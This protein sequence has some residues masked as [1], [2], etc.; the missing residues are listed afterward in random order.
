MARKMDPELLYVEC[1]QCGHP[2]LWAAGDT[3]RILLGAGIDPAS[4][5]ETCMIV[6]DGCP[7]CAPGEKVFSTHVVRLATDRPPARLAS[8]AGAGTS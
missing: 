7:R 3:T 8:G 6:S 1:A 4:L 2:L 5:D